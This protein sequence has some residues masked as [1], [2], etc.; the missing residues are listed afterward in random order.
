MLDRYRLVRRID[1][2]VQFFHVIQE[3]LIGEFI[4]E[5]GE[6]IRQK[7]QQNKEAD[8]SVLITG[9]AKA[10]N[11]IEFCIRVFQDWDDDLFYL[12]LWEASR[13]HPV[14]ISPLGEKSPVSEVGVDMMGA[15]E[16]SLFYPW[17]ACGREAVEALKDDLEDLVMQHLGEAL[18]GYTKLKFVP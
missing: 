6:V 2:R 4:Q 7:N 13:E 11:S 16:M 18:R 5:V 14:A 17:I 1:R 15:E 3:S 8:F 10:I 9:L 12:E